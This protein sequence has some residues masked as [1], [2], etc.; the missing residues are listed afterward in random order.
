MN[1]VKMKGKKIL[2]FLLAAAMTIGVITPFGVKAATK[3]FAD[4]AEGTELKPGDEIVSNGLRDYMYYDED[5]Q[6]YVGYAFSD[7]ETGTHKVLPYESQPGGADILQIPDGEFSHWVVTEIITENVNVPEVRMKAVRKADYNITYVLDGGQNSVDNP[8]SYHEGAGVAAFDD[9]TKDGYVFQGWYAEERF[10]NKV[11]SIS[12][13]ETGDKTLYAK[14]EKKATPTP[15]PAKEEEAIDS[16]NNSTTDNKDVSDEDG[17]TGAVN[18]EKDSK[19][20]KFGLLRAKSKKQTRNSVTI[21]WTKLKNAD[22]YYVYGSICN[23]GG[24]TYKRK[25]I[26]TFNK[27]TVLKYVHKGLKKGTYY[28]YQIKAFKIVKG[29]KKVFATSV[30]VHAT[31][32]GGKYGVA[33]A[34]KVTKIGKKKISSQ[35]NL[36]TTL[37]KGKSIKVS[38]KE[39][40]DG[41]P[42]STHRYISYESENK[43]IASVTS[44]G[45]IK[46]K[47][48]GSTKVYVYAQNGVY[49]VIKV[50]V[51]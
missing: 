47:K 27:N 45:K 33:K 26:K 43:K 34:L 3:Q 14:F 6:G 22:G 2:A 30:D 46:A 25:K 1:R 17:D 4:L 32:K 29:K 41:R 50:T 10:V 28:K 9:A 36:K 35:S 16:N 13:E 38:A 12:A 42:I 37:K 23:H 39:I 19:K 8:D 21:T 20:S 24:K 11:T 15:V 31:T 49:Q 40:S 18:I 48:K 5:G 7:R 51:K 44:N